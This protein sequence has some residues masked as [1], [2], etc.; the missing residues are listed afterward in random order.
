MPVARAGGLT[1][2][3]TMGRTPH[4]WGKWPSNH[5]AGDDIVYW[6]RLF[7]NMTTDA[8]VIPIFAHLPNIPSVSPGPHLSRCLPRAASKLLPLDHLFHHLP[9]CER[10]VSGRLWGHILSNKRSIFKSYIYTYMCVCACVYVYIYILYILNINVC[11]YLYNYIYICVS[12]CPSAHFL[13]TYIK[14]TR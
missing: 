4:V 3:S 1:V 12:S 8:I 9:W 5:L 10:C 2:S 6:F 11:I 14:I 13:S 7:T